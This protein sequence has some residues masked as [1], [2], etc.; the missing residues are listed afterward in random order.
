MKKETRSYIVNILKSEFFLIDLINMIVGIA[1]LSFALLAFIKGSMELFGV[2]FIFGAV[3]SILNLL[4]VII[5]R[6][7]MGILAFSGLTI[8]MFVMISVIYGYFLR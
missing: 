6:S 7:L 3:L 5:R 1:V 2:V 8:S 4:K